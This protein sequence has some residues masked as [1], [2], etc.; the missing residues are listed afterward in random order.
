MFEGRGQFV[1]ALSRSKDDLK[2]LCNAM[3]GDFCRVYESCGG[4]KDK[5]TRFVLQWHQHCSSFL[6]DSAEDQGLSPD[7]DNPQ[8]IW[9]RLSSGVDASIKNPVMISFCAAVFDNLLIRIRTLLSGTDRESVY[10]LTGNIQLER[11][12]DDVHLRFCGA[13]LATMYKERYKKMKSKAIK[14]KDDVSKELTVLDWIRMTDKN[15]L[16]ESLKYKDEGGMYFPHPSFV[17][18]IRAVDECVR[19]HANETSFKRYGSKLV[20]VSVPSS[21]YLY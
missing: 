17:P 9:N 8:R 19:E 3:I 6:M 21:T 13:A 5:Y 12:S 11:E 7:E 16:P 15:V 2:L 20:Q 4:G 18:F 10:K 1:Q 14:N